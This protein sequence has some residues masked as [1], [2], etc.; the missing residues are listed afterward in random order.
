MNPFQKFVSAHAQLLREGK[1]LPLNK[2]KPAPRREIPAHT[3]KVLLFSPHPDDECIIGGLALRLASEAKWN[4][5]NVAVTLGSD[6]KRRNARLAELQAACRSLGFGLAVAGWEDIHPT[7]RRENQAS[8]HEAVRITAE[9]LTEQQ[10]HAILLP[11]ANDRHPTHVGTHLLVMDALKMLPP[12]F[13]CHVVETEF[14]GQMTEPNLLVEISAGHLA[15]LIAA[16]GCHT[17]EVRRNAF[18]VR[19]PAWMMDNVRRGSELVSG[20]GTA[21]PDFAF[22][23][24]YRLGRW[25]DGKLEADAGGRFLPHSENAAKLFK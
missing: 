21:A 20:L 18:H 22:G 15:D 2:S 9:I 5:I 13:G 7:A 11:H 4:V 12:A 16:L 3:P 6:V 8:W 10:P 1:K 17:G 23:T 14:W 25:R 24:I 19:L